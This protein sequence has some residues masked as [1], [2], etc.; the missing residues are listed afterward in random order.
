MANPRSSQASRALHPYQVAAVGTLALIVVLGST[1]ASLSGSTSFNLFYS[2]PIRFPSAA[3]A[4][5]PGTLFADR[6]NLLNALFVK[7]IWG[8][9]TLAFVAQAVVLRRPWSKLLLRASGSEERSLK[10]PLARSVLRFVGATTAWIF[11]TSWFLGPSL[12]DR[13]FMYTGGHCRLEI[14]ANGIRV[15]SELCRTRTAISY[16]THPQLFQVDDF[17]TANIDPSSLKD[18]FP[19]LRGGYD[20]SGHTFLLVLALLFMME[21]IV[22]F[23]PYLFLRLPAS[24]RPSKA[25][26]ESLIP[27]SQWA[28]LDPFHPSGTSARDGNGNGGAG[29]RSTT[30]GEGI[31]TT[32]GRPHIQAQL[33]A[34]A[35]LMHMG[36]SLWMLLMTQ[37]YFHT[38]AEKVAGLAVGVFSWYM[39][40][41]DVAPPRPVASATKVR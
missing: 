18:L 17:K 37:L 29:S 21:E 28:S 23:V 12:V 41:K 20:M 34:G 15:P 26:I 31:L 40:P 14:G 1:Y 38:L 39:L 35:L 13:T 24:I 30:T 22:P 6:R 2:D 25:L 8:W 11:F 36:L 9:T 3:T 19:R 27:R 16:Q 33:T 5:Q 10:D 32:I 7:R 4:S